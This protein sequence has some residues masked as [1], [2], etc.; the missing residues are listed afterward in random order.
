MALARTGALCAE[1]ERC[2]PER[3]FEVEFW[4]GRRLPATRGTGVPRF[5]VRSPQAVAHALRAPGQLGIAR[6]YVSGQL[7]VDDIGAA[8]RLLDSWEP[9]PLQLAD[10]ARLALSAARACGV[11][12]LPSPPLMELSPRGR[13][14]SRERDARAVRH[15][16]DVPAEFFALFLDRS[17]T[18]SCAIF[19][20]GAQTLEEAQETKLELVCTKLSLEPGQRVLDVGCGW[21]SFAVHAASRHRVRVTGITLSGP[22]ALVARRRVQEA[23]LAQHIDIRV[24]DYRQ[25]A[26]ERFDAIASIGMVEHVGAANID[27]Y[28]RR[29]AGLLRPGG[30]LLNHGIARL[31]HGD[32][33]AG[34]FSQ[35]YVFPDAAPLHLSRVIAALEGAG[36]E[37][38]HVEGFRHDY[39]ETL[40]HWA[41]RLDDSLAQAIKLAGPERVRVWRLYLRA[42]RNGFETGFT[43]VYQT[44]CTRR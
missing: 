39:A 10:R 38:T 30:R 24:M 1:L 25:L 33:E 36:L 40:R 31:R 35:R 3:P 23:G 13:R 12:P 34:P 6:A 44:L 16:Y 17:M 7:E 27:P 9:P 14:H 22:Q 4:D 5:R 11:G 19:S 29:L 26:G 20:R 37:T 32:P 28:A 18:Y 2:L 43:S 15:H 42:A 8:I 41:R 21:G